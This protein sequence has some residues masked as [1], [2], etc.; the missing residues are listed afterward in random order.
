MS[1]PTT[2]ASV[3]EFHQNEPDILA[4]INRVP[5]GAELF[6]ADPFRFLSEHGFALSPGLQ[7]E[8]QKRAPLLAKTPKDRY[9]GIEKGNV[10]LIDSHIPITW[11]IR[12]LGV[13]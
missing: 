6:I 8:L 2:I 12:S 1:P 11:Y 7:Q 4:V 5:R 3:T 9:D 10:A 13:E